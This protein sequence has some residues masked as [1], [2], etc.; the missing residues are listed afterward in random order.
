MHITYYYFTSKYKMDFVNIDLLISIRYFEVQAC[1]GGDQTVGTEA[2][3]LKALAPVQA[4]QVRAKMR[5]I[6][7]LDSKIALPPQTI[8][9][10]ITRN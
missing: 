6:D 4:G 2:S 10:G 5:S 9:S 3:K 7:H 1:Y 8:S